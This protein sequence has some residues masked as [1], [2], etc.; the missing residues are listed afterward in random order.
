[1]TGARSATLQS[2]VMIFCKTSQNT[3][4]LSLKKGTEDFIQSLKNKEMNSV[5]QRNGKQTKV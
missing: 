2:K 5:F 3:D 4:F 1:M